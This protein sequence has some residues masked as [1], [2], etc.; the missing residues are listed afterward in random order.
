LDIGFEADRVHVVGA[1]IDAARFAVTPVSGRRPR[2][3]W[4]NRL[5]PTKGMF[6]L[7]SIARQLHGGVVIDVV[8]RGPERY[9]SRL[10]TELEQAGVSDR[11]LLHGFVPDDKMRE[12]LSAASVFISCSYEEGWGIS[13]AEA[14]AAGL[15]CVAYDLPSHREIFAD[16]IARVPLSDT[17]AFAKAINEFVSF[18]DT[19]ELRIERRSMASR[20]S[21]DECAARQEAVFAALMV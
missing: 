3:I 18:N 21:L 13:I 14:L 12:M 2:A 15:P 1:G 7:P 10:R 11:V 8:G 19:D 20:F 9:A 4:V 16:A 6:D 17:A 5:E